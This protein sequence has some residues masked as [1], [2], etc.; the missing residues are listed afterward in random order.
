MVTE[1]PQDKI[2]WH[3]LSLRSFLQVLGYRITDNNA[4]SRIDVGSIGK[5]LVTKVFKIAM[6]LGKD[7][8]FPTDDKVLGEEEMGGF[9]VFPGD[10]PL[11]LDI[12][13]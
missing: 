3:N 4:L 12:A 10:D 8:G 7:V 2:Y 13:L 9:P 5:A 1:L 6:D 11:D